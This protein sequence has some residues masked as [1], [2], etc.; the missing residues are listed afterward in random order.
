MAI[1]DLPDDYEPCVRVSQIF[2]RLKLKLPAIIDYLRTSDSE[3]AQCIC[4]YYDRLKK[5]MRPS[6]DIDDLIA[7]ARAD[8]YKIV[9]IAAEAYAKINSLEAQMIAA[10]A[11][12][13]I[14]ERRAEYAMRPE[15]HADAKL[16][17][18]TTGN[19]PTPKN[20]ITNYTLIGNRVDNSKNL[21]VNTG[22]PSLE[23]VVQE[24]ERPLEL[25]DVSS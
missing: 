22:V 18:Q 24:A 1:L 16:I 6:V 4:A 13:K 8:R 20:N 25:N 9:G 14:M 3:S 11:S 2:Q 21:T 17:L 15:F 12:P 5:S 19:V 7:A 23:S 10:G